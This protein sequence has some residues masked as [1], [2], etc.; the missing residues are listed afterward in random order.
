[1]SNSDRARQNSDYVRS[2]LKKKWP[3]FAAVLEGVVW[4]LTCTCD[5]PSA[6][7]PETR[8]NLQRL[9]GTS[10]PEVI[11]TANPSGHQGWLTAP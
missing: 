3:E 9:L 4:E 6:E 5:A 8:A 11:G 7:W 1:M 10:T 2:L